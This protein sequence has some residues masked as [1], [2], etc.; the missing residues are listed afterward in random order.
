MDDADSLCPIVK[1]F[2]PT[3]YIYS[4][5]TLKSILNDENFRHN[6]LNRLQKAV[7]VPTQIYDG[8]VLPD[9][10][11]LSNISAQLE[12][13][14]VPFEDFQI[15][16]ENAF[17][18]VHEHLK[19]EKI[20]RLGLVYTWEGSNTSKKPIM[21]MAHYD[22]VPVQPET[23]DQ[24]TFPPFE[25]AY[26]GQYVYGRGVL[27]CKNLLVGIMETIELLLAEGHFFPQ[28]TIILS[29]GYDEEAAGTG[30][31]KI[32]KH[33]LT[34]YGPASF[35]QIIDE[36]NSGYVEVEGNKYILPAIS[37]KGHLNSILEL[38]TPGGHSS[39]PPEHTSIGLLSKVISLIEDKEFESILSNANPVLNEMQCVAENSQSIGPTL[40]KTILKAH[41]NKNA[42]K[43]LLEYLSR[44]SSTKFL[45]RTSQAVDVVHGGIK[46][47]ALPEHVSVLINHR[48]A[49]ED[50]VASTRQKIISQVQNFAVDFGLGL[51]CDGET[52]LN[53]TENGFFSYTTDEPLEPAP[54]TPV[55]DGVW[56]VFGGSLRYLYEDLLSPTSNETYIFA[57]YIGTGNTDTKSYWNLTKNIFRY[58]PGT[59]MLGSNVHS[60]DEKLEFDSHL[61]IIAFY[62]YYLQVVDQLDESKIDT[63]ASQ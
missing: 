2:N 15:Y 3:A 56:E 51:I 8:M 31:E 1:K 62:Y 25:G 11:S 23:I 5:N 40:R 16:L 6:T 21:L 29:F 58:V 9:Y 38:Y 37:E 59:S 22:V 46:S 28:R 10:T 24:W 57:P 54:L 30:A 52:V 43:D 12:E 33:L 63:P 55:G 26:D 18:L 27:D 45:V 49:L 32:S 53:K 35:F 60:V 44:D 4:N 19:L 36:G 42:N 48:I 17:P 41:L 61:Q 13:E 7:Q 34:R 20:N 47:N 39:I 14:W 50:S